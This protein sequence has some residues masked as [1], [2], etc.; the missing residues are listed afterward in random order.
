MQDIR[1]WPDTHKHTSYG[2]N[3]N[4]LSCKGSWLSGKHLEPAARACEMENR[5]SQYDNRVTVIYLHVV[6]SI[7]MF[8]SSSQ[9][10]GL[11]HLSLQLL[12]VS[13]S[14]CLHRFDEQN[15]V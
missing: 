12:S 1:W 2:V 3:F 10:P 15:K 8:S 5:I 13:R 6:R 4:A 14:Q 11:L 7:H 9:P